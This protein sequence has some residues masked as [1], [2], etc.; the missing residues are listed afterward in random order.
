MFNWL[1]KPSIS[2][3]FS[4]VS[5]QA[6]QIHWTLPLPPK[7]SQRMAGKGSG[8][9]P[10]RCTSGWRRWG[11]GRR[12]LRMFVWL[13]DVS[14]LAYRT[15]WNLWF[16]TSKMWWLF[17]WIPSVENGN[18]RG[19]PGN[20]KSKTFL[21]GSREMSSATMRPSQRVN[22][23]IIGNGPLKSCSR[24]QEW[25]TYIWIHFMG[26]CWNK[27]TADIQWYP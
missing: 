16:W 26:Q 14:K 1:N 6:D 13:K 27:C 25:F 23:Q 15:W 3:V 19:Q 10:C 2:G 20:Q 24:C 9:A 17:V 8:A 11:A 7:L 21:W 4:K 12:I 5:V 22:A 18:F